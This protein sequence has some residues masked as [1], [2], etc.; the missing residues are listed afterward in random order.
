ML[1][2]SYDESVKNHLGHI[3]FRGPGADEFTLTGAEGYPRTA[4]CTIRR[5][6]DDFFICIVGGRM[7]VI[8]RDFFVGRHSKKICVDEG[9]SAIRK[10][11]QQP[12]VKETLPETLT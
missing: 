6:K 12:T 3:T 4:G 10:T 8:L 9:R 5:P 7:Y 1:F 2:R 11:D